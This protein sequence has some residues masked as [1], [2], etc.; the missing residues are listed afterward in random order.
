MN[1]R[2]ENEIVELHQ[3]FED[4]F[5]GRLNNSDQAFRR[6]EDVMAR[7]FT[8]VSP[9][10]RVTGRTDLLHSLRSAHGAYALGGAISIRVANILERPFSESNERSDPGDPLA[11]SPTP[12]R[13]TDNMLASSDITL[14]TYEEWQDEG[15]GERGRISSA[16]FRS[17]V[18][19]PNGL[20][21]LHVHET[22]LS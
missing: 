14:V 5:M 21:W 8:M 22:W 6:V 11:G 1:K 2:C 7:G 16:L 12:L 9:E 4:W 17:R 19:T 10:G 18:G 20:E 13:D 3:F 15:S